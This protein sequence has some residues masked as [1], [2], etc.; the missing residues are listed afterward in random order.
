MKFIVT[1]GGSGGHVFPGVAVARAL[2]E[3]GHEVALMLSGRA[4]EGERPAGWDGEI[5][6]VNITQPRVKS[7]LTLLKYAASFRIC[8]R[9]VRKFKPDA[10]L[11]MG[12]YTSVPPAVAAWRCGVPVVAHEGNAVP[13]AAVK[14][15]SRFAKV[16]CLA[17]AGCAAHF[18]KNVKTVVTGLPLREGTI[19]TSQN[20]FDKK[21]EPTL[22]VMGGSQGARSLNNA[23]AGA[24]R[25][26]DGKMKLRIVHLAGAKLESEVRASYE[27]V[28]HIA[29]EVIGFSNEMGRLYAEADFCVSRA[30]ASSCF[31]LCANGVPA[32]FVPL[33][34]VSND[35]QYH[36]AKCMVGAGCAEMMLQSDATP[37]V[38]ATRLEALIADTAKLRAM[39]AA[40]LRNAQTGSPAAKLAEAVI[41]NAT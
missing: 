39:S 34:K 5:L 4:V 6:R 9:L 3:A 24:V 36:N 13:G 8:H 22:L 20:N 41:A 18:P 14:F 25:I 19:D 27:G 11:A 2:R 29:V 12:S 32:L 30:G 15:I 35:H 26:L 16:V 23:V 10:M 1:C 37:E 38:L 21:G 7:P 33:P 28:A 40:A 17:F 31:E